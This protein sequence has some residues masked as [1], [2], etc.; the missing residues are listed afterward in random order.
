MDR[1]KNLFQALFEK[2]GWSTFQITSVD[3]TDKV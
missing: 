3:N 2:K 1:K